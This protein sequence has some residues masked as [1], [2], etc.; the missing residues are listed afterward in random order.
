[1]E[2][3]W[4]R[5]FGGEILVERYWW[6]SI[7]GEVLVERFRWRDI[8]GEIL[9]ERAWSSG[10]AQSLSL[11]VSAKSPKMPAS[12]PAFLTISL[13]PE[14]SWPPV[15][16]GERTLHEILFYSQ[17]PVDGY[18]LGDGVR[19]LLLKSGLPLIVLSQIWNLADVSNDN[20]L[21]VHEFVLVM[22]LIRGVMQ[23][24]TLPKTLPPNLTPPKTNPAA[25]PPMSQQEKD[26]YSRVFQSF[27][28]AQTGFIDGPVAAEIFRSSQLADDVLIQI[29]DLADFGRDGRLSV[30]EFTVA[31]HLMRYVQ[32]GGQLNG[33]IDL[34][35]YA[36]QHIAQQSLMA[37]KRRIAEYESHKQRLMSLKER[38]KSQSEK[39]SRRLNLAKTKVKLFQELFDLLTSLNKG[40]EP[41]ATTLQQTIAKEKSDVEKQ[42]EIVDRLKKEHE[43]V[44]QETVKIILGEQKLNNDVTVIKKDT[45][46][47]NKRLQ[48][49]HTHATKDQDPFHRLYEQ[50]RE[51]RQG[52]TIKDLD[53]IDVYVPFGFSPFDL[54][55]TP[56]SLPSGVKVFAKGDSS[57]EINRE[58]IRPIVANLKEFREE[59]MKA[60]SRTDSVTSEM[61]KPSDE[62]D[63]F[64]YVYD[65]SEDNWPDWNWSEEGLL[66]LTSDQAVQL[67]IKLTDLREAIQN[68]NSDGGRLVFVSTVCY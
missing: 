24:M 63:V 64:K 61:P 13:F 5:A 21:D 67:K 38:R 23:G 62:D 6:K 14:P 10:S 27:D 43:K 56:A 4:W 37:R 53:K 55:V 31:C 22:H 29:W 44:R 45:D 2:R 3:Y 33:P 46:E 36:P 47:L 51:K 8:G 26:A 11:E 9:V 60:W 1:M 59:F 20:V 12:Y 17:G 48:A 34:F 18:I 41:E 66:G 52:S 58:N 19:D 54:S 25:S 35:Q 40:A 57:T 32:Q 42:E 15:E 68:L 30:D 39:E 16:Q 65:W 7:G 49:V 50:R 28:D